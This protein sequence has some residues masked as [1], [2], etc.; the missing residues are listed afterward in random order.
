MHASVAHNLKTKEYT[1]AAMSR[2]VVIFARSPEREAAAK[3]LPLQHAVPLFQK[4]VGEWLH[5]AT[6][7]DAIPVIACDEEDRESLAAILP[8][9]ARLWV[10]QRGTAFSQRL[11]IAASD[12]FSLGFKAIVIAAIDAPPPAALCDA[13]ETIEGGGNVVAASA[14]GGVNLVGLEARDV[15]VLTSI[16]AR[17]RDVVSLLRSRFSRLVVLPSATDVDDIST[18]CDAIGTKVIHEIAP[19]VALRSGTF[20]EDHVRPWRTS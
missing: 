20:R 11:A 15:D 18:L 1:L 14:D 4:H 13:F 10:T 17:H 12:T 8:E 5:A 9:R 16:Q 6:S 19:P 3:N 7:C 2:A